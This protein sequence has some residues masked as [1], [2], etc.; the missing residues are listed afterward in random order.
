MFFCK[1]TDYKCSFTVL[2]NSGV[3]ASVHYFGEHMVAVFLESILNN[4]KRFILIVCVD[5]FDIFQKKD[6]WLLRKLVD[7]SDD[8]KKYITSFIFKPFPVA[9]YWESLTGKAADKNINF[10][11]FFSLEPIDVFLIKGMR[12]VFSVCP[13]GIFIRIWGPD[14]F[15]LVFDWKT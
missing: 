12:K 6:S 5:I 15:K 11:Q 2:R 3:F 13:C 7:Y 9:G 4:F 10:F 14:N 1:K 8:L